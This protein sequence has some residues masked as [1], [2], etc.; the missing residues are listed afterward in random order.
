MIVL[1]LVFEVN[2]FLTQK[3]NTAYCGKAAVFCLYD[4][5]LGVIK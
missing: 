1:Y 5:L 2:T 4:L 3:Q